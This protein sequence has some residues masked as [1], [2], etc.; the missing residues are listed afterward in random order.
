MQ[1]KYTYGARSMLDQLTD[2]DRAEA[3]A[4]IGHIYS[5]LKRDMP[6]QSLMERISLGSISDMYVVRVGDGWRI[7]FKISDDE[8]SVEDVVSERQLEALRMTH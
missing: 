5:E 7:Y 3:E 4:T 8:L 6:P 1:L 2:R